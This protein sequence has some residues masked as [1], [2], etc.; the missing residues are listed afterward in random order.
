MNDQNNTAP[1]VNMMRYTKDETLQ[2]EAKEGLDTAFDTAISIS[3]QIYRAQAVLKGLLLSHRI[4][5]ETVAPN[6]ETGQIGEFD[7]NQ[8]GAALELALEVLSKIEGL[9]DGLERATNA[10]SQYLTNPEGARFQLERKRRDE[11]SLDTA[12][13]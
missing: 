9:M 10:A 13:A 4:K 3:F 8:E 7:L 2:R 11:G 5:A 12:T 1:V 6:H